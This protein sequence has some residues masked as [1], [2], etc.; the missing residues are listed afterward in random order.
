MNKFLW[1]GR[2][3][4]GVREYAL[5]LAILV[6]LDYEIGTAMRDGLLPLA[7]RYGTPW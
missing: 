2:R 7:Q 3:S 1:E 4:W 6:M 5:L